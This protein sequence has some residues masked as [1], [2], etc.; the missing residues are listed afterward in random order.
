MKG[1]VFRSKGDI[2]KA[3]IEFQSEI[4]YDHNLAAAYAVS[5]LV[6]ILQG[7]SKDAKDHI[8]TALRLSPRDPFT[9]IWKFWMCHSYTHQG[10]W[11]QAVLWCNRSISDKPYWMAFLDLAVAYAWLGKDKDAENAAGKLLDLMPGYTVQKW[12]KAD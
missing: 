6:N 10:M 12:A 4:E 3:E 9:N 1:D 11:D 2:D 7:H 8:S 5:G